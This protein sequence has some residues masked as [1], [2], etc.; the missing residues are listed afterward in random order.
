MEKNV[1]VKVVTFVNK[2]DANDTYSV[3]GDEDVSAQSFEDTIF[4]E[5]F[6]ATGLWKV[7]YSLSKKGHR[8]LI[9]DSSV[10]IKI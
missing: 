5:R 6:N 10:W 3:V 9:T 2:D 1:K 4:G 8:V 7:M